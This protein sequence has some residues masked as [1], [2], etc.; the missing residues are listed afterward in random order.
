MD[1]VPYDTLI[2][3]MVPSFVAAS[4]V[5]GEERDA[6]MLPEEAAALAGASTGRQKEFALGRTCARRALAKL[7]IPPVPILAGTHRE[8]LWPAGVAGSI[9]H[10]PNYCAAVVARKQQLPAIGIDAEIDAALPEGVLRMVALEEERSWLRERTEIDD[11][12]WDRVLFSAKECVYK[13]WFAVAA[14]WLDFKDVLL[15]LD[16]NGGTFCGQLLVPGPVVDG[17]AVRSFEG[18]FLLKE[19]LIITS[20]VLHA[21]GP[22]NE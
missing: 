8:P 3:G 18:R 6:A 11:T 17:R 12:H 10:C 7:G 21:Y 2:G 13:V 1:S 5:R 20:A 4:E 9:T 22:A 15:T 14:R 16:P 19:G